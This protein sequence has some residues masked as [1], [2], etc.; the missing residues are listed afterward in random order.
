MAPTPK[1]P[2]PIAHTTQ[3]GAT[4]CSVQMLAVQFQPFTKDILCLTNVSDPLQETH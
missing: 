2:Y 3:R 1:K 4:E